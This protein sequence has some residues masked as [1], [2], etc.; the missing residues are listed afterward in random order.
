MPPCVAKGRG[1][2]MKNNIMTAVLSCI[3]AYCVGCVT[4]S[5]EWA[6]AVLAGLLANGL[7][8]SDDDDAR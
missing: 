4:Q 1:E 6:I 5:P 2:E 3:S 8:I 7:Y